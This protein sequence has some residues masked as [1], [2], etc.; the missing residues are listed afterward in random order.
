MPEQHLRQQQCNQSMTEEFTKTSSE[1]DKNDSKNTP[2][3]I[4]RESN[5]LLNIGKDI[6]ISDVST[7]NIDDIRKNSFSCLF[8]VHNTISLSRHQQVSLET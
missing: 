3:E 5:Y 2:Q 7:T 4:R 6:S 8:S 1:S